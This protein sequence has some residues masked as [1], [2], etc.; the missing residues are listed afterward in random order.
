ML[1]SPV[2]SAAADRPS[3]L[4]RRVAACACGLL[5]T[6]MLVAWSQRVGEGALA[7]G[8]V[9]SVFPAYQPLGFRGAEEDGALS[10]RLVELRRHAQQRILL[11]QQTNAREQLYIPARYNPFVSEED[12]VRELMRQWSR[13]IDAVQALRRSLD[14]VDNCTADNSTLPPPDGPGNAANQTDDGSFAA[15][16]ETCGYDRFLLPSDP[17][18]NTTAAAAA[19]SPSSLRAMLAT[20]LSAAAELDSHI[21]HLARQTV[22]G[23]GGRRSSRD[24]QSV[25]TQLRTISLA[26]RGLVEEGPTGGQT[27]LTTALDQMDLQQ[28]VCGD[29]NG[30][31]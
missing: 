20:R 1:F 29:G 17:S 10:D 4:A 18:P 26:T 23:G 3:S 8:Y 14:C 30:G 22:D 19:D 16:L 27:A 12:T 15:C 24:L 2:V 6:A 31:R 21:R 25:A 7:E 5:A 11:Q 28:P 13:I 9:S